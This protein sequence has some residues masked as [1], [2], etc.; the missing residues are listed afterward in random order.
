MEFSGKFCHLMDKEGAA[1]SSPCC[2][3]KLDCV[4][5]EFWWYA[6]S[7]PVKEEEAAK[8]LL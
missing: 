2:V 8:T 4:T 6:D 7:K 3:E 5:Q 1:V